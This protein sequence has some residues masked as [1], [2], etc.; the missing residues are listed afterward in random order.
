MEGEEEGG[1]EGGRKGVSE[2]REP[3]SQPCMHMQ[4]ELGVSF[5]YISTSLLPLHI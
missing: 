2:E 1:M 5:S 4:E 3:A